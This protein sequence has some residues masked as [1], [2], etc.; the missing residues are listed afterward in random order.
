M[1]SG[2]AKTEP[3]GLFDMSAAGCP[4]EG[5]PL[6]IVNSMRLEH[7]DKLRKLFARCLLRIT[8]GSLS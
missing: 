2:L 8:M 4:G 5:R 7:L 3:P 6:E 1:P